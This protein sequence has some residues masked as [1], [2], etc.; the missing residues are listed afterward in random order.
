MLHYAVAL[1]DFDRTEKRWP[2]LVTTHVQPEKEH[3]DYMCGLG[4]NTQMTPK[5]QCYKL[6]SYGHGHGRMATSIASANYWSE[7]IRA[8]R[9]AH[10]SKV[11]AFLR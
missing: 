9:M 4:R 5:V 11:N 7:H 6:I 10:L 8:L 1:L 3:L 2:Q